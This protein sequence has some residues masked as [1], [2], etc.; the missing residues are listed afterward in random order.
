MLDLG[1]V[2]G[3]MIPDV[4]IFLSFLHNFIMG[5]LRSRLIFQTETEF[6]PPDSI[7]GAG[8]H[9]GIGDDDTGGAA[10]FTFH[11]KTFLSKTQINLR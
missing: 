6:L 11:K 4:S 9:L 10:R 3:V 7:V 8:N 1:Q 2:A 5:I